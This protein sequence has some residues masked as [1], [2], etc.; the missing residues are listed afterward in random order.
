MGERVAFGHQVGVDALEQFAAVNPR[1]A[2]QADAITQ[3]LCL[4]DVGGH[5][6][7]NTG[8]LYAVKINLCAKRQRSEDREFV[9]SINTVNIKAGVRLCIAQSLRILQ[10]RVKIAAMLFHGRQDI[11]AG[12]V[13]DAV[14]PLDTVGRSPVANAL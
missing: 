12:A 7:S 5:D 3:S 10:N 14:N 11:I 2:E 1:H 8:D 9:R 4:P 6:A 13:K